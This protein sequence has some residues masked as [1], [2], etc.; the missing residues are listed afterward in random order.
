[1]VNSCHR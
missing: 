1:M